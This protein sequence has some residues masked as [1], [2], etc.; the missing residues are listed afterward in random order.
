VRLPDLMGRS[1]LGV[2]LRLPADLPAERTLVLLA[3]RQRQQAQVDRWIE[4]AVRE[5]GVPASPLA[6]GFDGSRAVVEV[7][8]LGRRWRLARRAIDGGMASSIAQ[9]PILARTITVYDDV[10]RILRG[11]GA[12]SREAVQARVA[13]RTGAILAAAD[14]EPDGAGWAAIA[15]AMR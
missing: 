1:L 12:T 2:E 8:C 4:K 14:G 6:P 13:L 11:V 7:P 3:F 9:P 5:L 10:G 15:D